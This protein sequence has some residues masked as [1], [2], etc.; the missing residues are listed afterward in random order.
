[1]WRRVAFVWKGEY[2]G[3]GV[4]MEVVSG[5]IWVGMTA[6]DEMNWKC[7]G[8]EMSQWIGA[9]MV[10]RW[11]QVDGAGCSFQ[12]GNQEWMERSL[13]IGTHGPLCSMRMSLMRSLQE[14]RQSR[15]CSISVRIIEG[16]KTWRKPG[17]K[18]FA[19]WF[20]DTLEYYHLIVT[21]LEWEED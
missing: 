9:M 15:V 19:L 6:S 14:V 18:E 21:Y 8:R 12:I 4:E 5:L 1:M 10:A 17:A 3:A 16:K 7:R 2:A 11:M 13:C 20:V